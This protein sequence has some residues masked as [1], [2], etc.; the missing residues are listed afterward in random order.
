MILNKIMK[1]RGGGG[2][3]GRRE[4]VVKMGWGGGELEH[5]TQLNDA[6]LNGKRLSARAADDAAAISYMT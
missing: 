6:R 4:G 1:V 5:E 2:V 3:G